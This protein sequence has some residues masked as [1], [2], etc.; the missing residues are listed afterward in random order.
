VFHRPKPTVVCSANGRRKE[1]IGKEVV[2]DFSGR[3]LFRHLP[4]GS[5]RNHEK[6]QSDLF[7]C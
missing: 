3:L 6:L 1:G 4:V 5:G 2:M 7:E